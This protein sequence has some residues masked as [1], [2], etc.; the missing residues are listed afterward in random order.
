MAMKFKVEGENDI[1]TGRASLEIQV[2]CYE[3]GNSTADND[4]TD[5]SI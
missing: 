1:G 4:Y 5:D 2:Y 3:G